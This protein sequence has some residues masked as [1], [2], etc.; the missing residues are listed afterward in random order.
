[1][2]SQRV[3]R[4]AEAFAS[5]RRA[6]PAAVISPPSFTVPIL[7]SITPPVILGVASL[8]VKSMVEESTRIVPTA[9]CACSSVYPPPAM[10]ESSTYF[11]STSS[12]SVENVG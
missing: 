12:V 10:I 2:L 8:Y 7:P 6:F 5:S 4:C 1:M 9:S 3:V 11:L